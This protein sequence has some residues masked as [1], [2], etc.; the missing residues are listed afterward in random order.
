[1]N[2]YLG[3]LLVFAYLAIL[4]CLIAN[5]VIAQNI[6][7]EIQ[8]TAISSAQAAQATMDLDADFNEAKNVIK[9]I[10]DFIITKL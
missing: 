10:Y 9:A 6:Y 2:V 7:H 1:M 3:I 5:I 4:G 8:K